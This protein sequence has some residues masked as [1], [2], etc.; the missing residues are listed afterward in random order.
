VYEKKFQAFSVF[1]LIS[2]FSTFLAEPP[3][4][5]GAK[6]IIKKRLKWNWGLRPS[7]RGDERKTKFYFLVV[8]FSNFPPF[9]KFPAFFKFR[10]I[11]PKMHVPT[12]VHASLLFSKKAIF[13]KAIKYFLPL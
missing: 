11:S 2:I 1:D 6:E 4:F 7:I 3:F 9:F 10:A 12:P 13:H 8:F 5:F